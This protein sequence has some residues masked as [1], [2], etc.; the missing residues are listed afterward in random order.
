MIIG[1]FRLLLLEINSFL[2]VHQ[3]LAHDTHISVAV[4]WILLPFS[5]LMFYFFTFSNHAF[6]LSIFIGP[7]CFHYEHA[8]LVAQSCLTVT[9]RTVALQAPLLW[10]SPGKNTGVG[11]RSLL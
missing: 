3:L 4:F 2:Y 7:T 8:C 10:D 5:I 6:L 1:L 9:P 11:S